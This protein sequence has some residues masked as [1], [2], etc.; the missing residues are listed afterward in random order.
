MWGFFKKSEGIFISDIILAN[1]ATAE[2]HH[3]PPRPEEIQDCRFRL[4]LNVQIRWLR[5][6]IIEMTVKWKKKKKRG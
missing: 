6:R 1:L 3:E 2:G 5:L 4:H